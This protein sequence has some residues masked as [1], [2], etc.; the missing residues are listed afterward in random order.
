MASEV[1]SSNVH[2]AAPGQMAAAGP[3]RLNTT[4]YDVISGLQTGLGPDK[5]NLVAAVIV[6]WLRSGRLTLAR[7]LTAA[8]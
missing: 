3:T 7:N 4:L 5:D 2:T 6:H 8:S 1:R